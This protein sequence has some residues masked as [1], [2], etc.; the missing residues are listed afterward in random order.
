MSLQNYLVILGRQ[1][2]LGLI[3]LESVLGTKAVRPFGRH[4]AL[5]EDGP[6]LNRLGGILKLAR[7][8]YEGPA[9]EL[10]DLPIDAEILPLHEGKTPFA[11]S[12]YGM[13]ATRRYTEVVGLA[14]KKRLRSRGSVRLVAPTE[15]LAVSAA[16]LK[17]NQV[18]E[19]GFELIVVVAKQQMI[20]G[21]TVAVQDVDAYAARDHGR[22]ARSA[23]VGMLPPKLA[24]ILINTTSA[25]AVFDPFCGTGVV[26][27]EARLLGRAALGSDL[28]AEMVAAT[29]T[30]LKW[31]DHSFSSLGEWRGARQADAR[32]VQ[33]PEG[34]AIVSEGYLGPNLSAPPSPEHLAHIKRDLGTLYRETLQNWARQLPSGA[35]L[36][37]CVPA[38]RTNKGWSYLCLVDELPDLGYT[39][40][41]FQAV[42]APPLYARD[43][44]IVGRQLLFMRKK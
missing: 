33:L 43:T 22:P 7:V 42:T 21:Q 6:N 44:Q 20:I 23:T 16:G 27:Q 35:E 32:Q 41:G 39:L 9:R 34:A 31:L 40:K 10:R 24:Q 26:L 25:P 37:L 29:E 18:L 2:E 15:G 5:L 11:V 30:N 14:L 19:K 12:L 3:E 8:L 1:P 36:A 28:S 38:W 17:H 13:Q 4:A